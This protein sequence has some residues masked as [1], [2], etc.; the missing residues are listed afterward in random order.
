MAGNHH[1]AALSVCG[2]VYTWGRGRYGQLGHGTVTSLDLPCA[3][4]SLAAV[5]V[6]QVRTAPTVASPR[7]PR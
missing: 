3:I 1:S 2:R 4:A 5:V 7:C 6:S